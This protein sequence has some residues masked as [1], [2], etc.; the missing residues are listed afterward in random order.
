MSEVAQRP[1]AAGK[2][3]FRDIADLRA[4]PAGA[5]NGSQTTA[6]CGP[7]MAMRAPYAL[8]IHG[9]RKRTL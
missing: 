5:N 4:F 6:L 1:N 3:L 8:A 9:Y 7:G 2:Y